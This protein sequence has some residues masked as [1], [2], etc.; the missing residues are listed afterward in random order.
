VTFSKW[1]FNILKKFCRCLK[2]FYLD[3]LCMV[4]I[5]LLSLHKT[6]IQ[7]VLF[8]IYVWSSVSIVKY[9]SKEPIFLFAHSLPSIFHVSLQ[10]ALDNLSKEVGSSVRVVSFLR[11]EVGEGI[12]RWDLTFLV[13]YIFLP[14]FWSPVICY[15]TVIEPGLQFNSLRLI[16]V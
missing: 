14:C 9:P 15:H 7:N 12:A 3:H 2:N 11:M 1:S 4:K 16:K 8:I 6:H 5:L 10:E 13:I